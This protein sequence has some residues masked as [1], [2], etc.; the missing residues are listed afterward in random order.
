MTPQAKN[1]EGVESLTERSIARGVAVMPHRRLRTPIRILEEAM[2]ARVLSITYA[3]ALEILVSS[4]RKQVPIAIL[5]LGG[6]LT[7][8]WIVLVIWIPLWLI[9]SAISFVVSNVL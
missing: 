8:L 6:I 3:S 5:G 9:A 1:A 7:V 2:K 4:F